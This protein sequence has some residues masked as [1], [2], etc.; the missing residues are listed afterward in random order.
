M[1]FLAFI[2][3]LIFLWNNEILKRKF[4][5]IL[6]LNRPNY[7]HSS[8]C[9]SFIL[10][11]LLQR[12]WMY[13][14]GNFWILQLP[15]RNVLNLKK[16]SNKYILSLFNKF[17]ENINL[18]NYKKNILSYL[19]FFFGKMKFFRKMNFFWKIKKI[20]LWENLTKINWKNYKKY[21]E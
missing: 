20:I 14:Y 2:F 13:Q 1:I 3:H 7:N 17:S 5:R 10:L 11:S 12:W 15:T 16:N 8:T 21:F 19:N 4:V 18:E 9:T 6:Y